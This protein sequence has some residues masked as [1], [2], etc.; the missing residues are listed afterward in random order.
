MQFS[1]IIRSKWVCFKKSIGRNLQSCN[2]GARANGNDG[3]AAT[4]AFPTTLKNTLAENMEKHT[5]RSRVDHGKFHEA[6]LYYLFQARSQTSMSIQPIWLMY[7]FK[8]I[9]MSHGHPL[10]VTCTTTSH[11]YTYEKP[12][13]LNMRLQWACWSWP[14]TSA[15]WTATLPESSIQRT[16]SWIMKDMRS[17]DKWTDKI[18]YCVMEDETLICK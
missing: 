13:E 15:S 10:S 8:N 17:G 2:A 11:E 9:N 7:L 4:D 18:N 5:R 16:S 14:P 1:C 6:H 3:T 12:W